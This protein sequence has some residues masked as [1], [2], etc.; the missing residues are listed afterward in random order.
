MYIIAEPN[1]Q[2]SYQTWSIEIAGYNGL[3]FIENSPNFRFRKTIRSVGIK[4]VCESH[5]LRQAPINIR[6][7]FLIFGKSEHH[8]FPSDGLDKTISIFW[9][10][11]NDSHLVWIFVTTINSKE[12][13]IRLVIM[14][15]WQLGA[16][17]F[18]IALLFTDKADPIVSDSNF[19]PRILTANIIRL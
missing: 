4:V 19:H 1:T 18:Q 6:P 15:S 12:I 7:Y 10:Q 17:N 11:Y 3:I 9:K 2:P 13:C 16:I 8:F 5:L 14:R